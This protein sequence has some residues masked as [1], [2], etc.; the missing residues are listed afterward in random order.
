VTTHIITTV[1]TS[2]AQWPHHHEHIEA[3]QL[4]NGATLTRAQVIASI[5]AGNSFLTAGTPY[6]SVYV[7]HCPHCAAGDYI[8]THPDS[9]TAN[10]LLHLPRY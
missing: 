6:G 5:R 3:V 9:T 8:T 1:R 7:H 10:N 4:S 2:H